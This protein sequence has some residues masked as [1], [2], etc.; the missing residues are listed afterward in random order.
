VRARILG[1][2][3]TARYYGYRLPIPTSDLRKRLVRRRARYRLEHP[4]YGLDVAEHFD[5]GDVLHLVP[6][7]LGGFGVEQAPRVHL[8]PLDPRRCDR[9]GPQEEAGERLCVGQCLAP[10]SKRGSRIQGSTG[11]GQVLAGPPVP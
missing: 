4:R 10:A 3:P 11:G 5:G 7:H 6:Q 8:E 1:R 9:L 2:A